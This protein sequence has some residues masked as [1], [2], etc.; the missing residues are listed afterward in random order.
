[1]TLQLAHL[2]AFRNAQTAYLSLPK[3]TV[4]SFFLCH[5]DD[6][7]V[8]GTFNIYAP[9][10]DWPMFNTLLKLDER[11]VVDRGEDFITHRYGAIYL[12]L[13]VEPTDG[14]A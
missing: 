11:T 14:R 13:L 10:E 7:V 9:V 4:W 6:P 2:Q 1:M 3:D 12:S 5:N 8:P